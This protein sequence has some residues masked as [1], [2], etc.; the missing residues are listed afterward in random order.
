MR[1]IGKISAWIVMGAFVLVC[2]GWGMHSS[3]ELREVD[4][5]IESD[6]HEE[7]ALVNEDYIREYIY[8]Q[9]GVDLNLLSSAEREL[10]VNLE[11]ILNDNPFVEKAK[12]FEGQSG[13]LHLHIDTKQPIARVIDANGKNYYITN[14]R[15][16]V[17]FSYSYSPRVIVLTGYI[18][19]V[20][21]EEWKAVLD[22]TLRIHEDE[23]LRP[24]VES[25]KLDRRQHAYLVPKVG[26]F[27]IQLGELKDVETKIA[28]LKTFYKSTF[29]KVNW[30]KYS[31]VNL[32]YKNQ[33][34]L[35]KNNNRT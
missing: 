12:V 21:Q 16:I 2:A 20:N 25:I 31:S 14:K 34:V 26:S 3:Y 10:L 17:P 35:K 5:N 19:K 29:D 8:D 27:S 13:S 30:A 28:K 22:L 9:L 6:T 7:A 11:N 1:N 15:D 4:I 32:D 18:P 33:I 24:M 23:F